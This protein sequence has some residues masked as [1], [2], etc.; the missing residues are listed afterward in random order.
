MQKSL[1]LLLFGFGLVLVSAST[2]FAKADIHPVY[3]GPTTRL[4]NVNLS[5]NLPVQYADQT[6]GGAQTLAAASEPA[7]DGYVT[8]SIKMSSATLAGTLILLLLQRRHRTHNVLRP[9]F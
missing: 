6:A 9:K 8:T 2:A 1:T 5:R 7:Q 3:F 4:F